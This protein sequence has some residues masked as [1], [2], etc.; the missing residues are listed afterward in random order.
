M[1]RGSGYI[2]AAVVVMRHQTGAEHRILNGVIVIVGHEVVLAARIVRHEA[3]VDLSA[4][5][6][7]DQEVVVRGRAVVSV[8]RESRVGP[9]EL[10]V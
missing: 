6:R 9:D 1:I 3:V 4:R 5:R 8:I 10:T 7:R 2:D